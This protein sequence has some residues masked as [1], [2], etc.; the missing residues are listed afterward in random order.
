MFVKT[1]APIGPNFFVKPRVIPGKV[2][3]QIFKKFASKNSIFENFEREGL[4]MLKITKNSSKY[5]DF[6]KSLKMRKKY[7]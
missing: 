2:Y 6:C 3:D 1:A 4:W 5:L 7:Y